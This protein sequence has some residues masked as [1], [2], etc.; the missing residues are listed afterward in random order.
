V[1]DEVPYQ[2]ATLVQQLRNE[3]E[4]AV[5]YGNSERVRAVDKQLAELGLKADAAEERKA[6]AKSDDAKSEP[7]QSRTVKQRQAT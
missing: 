7:P 6:A 5:A 2:Q 3:R 4:N 1:S